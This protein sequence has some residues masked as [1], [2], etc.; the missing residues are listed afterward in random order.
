[1]SN[2]IND[3]V[4][5]NSNRRKHFLGGMFCGF[6]LTIVFALGVAT[7]MEYKDQRWGGEW[8]WQDWTSTAIGGAIG[9]LIQALLLWIL[10]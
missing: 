10:W 3:I 5:D 9:Q 4:T 6:W 2:L 1:M 8:D 7:G